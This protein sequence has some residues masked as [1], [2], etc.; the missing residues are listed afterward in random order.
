MTDWREQERLRREERRREDK[1]IQTWATVV[2]TGL[3][4]MIVG[5]VLWLRAY[6]P[7]WMFRLA[8][9]PTRCLP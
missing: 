2:G 7:C 9:A 5:L 8:D 3:V 4:L 6:G 1:R